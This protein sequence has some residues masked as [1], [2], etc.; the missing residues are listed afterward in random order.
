[1][2]MITGSRENEIPRPRQLGKIREVYELKVRH[3][4]LDIIY[5]ISR[6]RVMSDEKFI[7]CECREVCD[8]VEETFDYSATHCAPSGG[9]HHTG[10]YTSK[11]CDADFGVD[12]YE[13]DE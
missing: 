10:F 13:E 2:A 8:I 7:C 11:C 12:N 3:G 1:M 9:I 4:L 5:S 6:G